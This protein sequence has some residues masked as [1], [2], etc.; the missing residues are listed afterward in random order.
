LRYLSM[1]D[2]KQP[3]INDI[4]SKRINKDKPFW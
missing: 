2:K 3:S 1:Y 4:K